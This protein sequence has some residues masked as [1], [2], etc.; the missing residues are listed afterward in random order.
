MIFIEPGK[1][2]N[3]LLPPYR[4]KSFAENKNPYF[5][6]VEFWFLTADGAQLN[7]KISEFDF[8]LNNLID[9]Y[10]NELYINRS[11]RVFDTII[12]NLRVPT[13]SSDPEI[14]NL[15][16]L[17]KLKSLEL[18]IFRLTPKEISSTLLSVNDDYWDYPAFLELFN[19]TYARKLS[20]EMAVVNNIKIKEAA[21]T[22]NTSFFLKLIDT[23][24]GLS[25][26]LAN[27]ALLKMLHDLFYS[28]DIPEQAIL[29]M[30]NSAT[31][32]NSKNEK[33][34]TASNNVLKK[35]QYLMP[36]TDGPVICLKNTNGS[37]V[38]TNGLND[39]YKYLI[40][41]DIEMIICREHIKYLQ[42]IEEKFSKYLEIYVILKK[43][44]LIEMKIFLDK[45][46]IP[47]THLVDENNC[48]IEDYKIKSFP[49]SFLL[50][51]HHRVVLKQ[52]KT[53]LDGFE[54]QFGNYLQQKL[55]EQ[56]KN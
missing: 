13:N 33:I 27:L 39:K 42:K 26:P 54:H 24:Y 19:K 20:S 35:L 23:K 7:D 9:K 49:Q 2:I 56:R 16:K 43:S 15:H 34:K 22:S 5:K 12:S 53:P 50:D 36:G 4:Q 21:I 47:G 48:Y 25:G 45:Q 8:R 38:C 1:T 6:P 46:N 3:L 44:D 41:A 18:D 17:L 14:L 52:S 51:E 11:E 10:F 31:F 37:N 32:L 29:T 55:F 28:G 30:I 40:F